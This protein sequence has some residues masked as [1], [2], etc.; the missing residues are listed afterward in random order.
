MNGTVF[1]PPAYMT[2]VPYSLIPAMTETF[3]GDDPHGLHQLQ[4]M[5]FRNSVP[6]SQAMRSIDVSLPDRT[7]YHLSVK[8]G[9]SIGRSPMDNRH[10]QWRASR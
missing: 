1:V 6:P 2:D 4:K 10:R 5:A 7:I 3:R 8:L 9:H